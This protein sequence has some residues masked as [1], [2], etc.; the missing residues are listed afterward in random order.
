[1][2]SRNSI[3]QVDCLMFTRVYLGITGSI[4]LLAKVDLDYYF[5]TPEPLSLVCCGSKRTVQS[6]G[7]IIS[8]NLLPDTT[9]RMTVRRIY[10]RSPTR[11]LE[12][13]EG[14]DIS[15]AIAATKD[16]TIQLLRS[17]KQVLGNSDQTASQ[18]RRTKEVD[19][20]SQHLLTGAA[21]RST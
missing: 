9:M 15:L 5:R 1:M 19:P 7:A 8:R 3:V 4:Y 16:S 14:S 11:N 18:T 20:V 21:F 12:A 10:T 6:H 17:P 2:V 13:M